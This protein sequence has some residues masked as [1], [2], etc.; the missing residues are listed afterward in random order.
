M[1]RLQFWYEFASPY[2]Y[3][4]A[5][6]IEEEA[7]EA[8]VEADWRPFLL[9][10][11]FAK[12]DWKTS[13]FNLFPE[14]G[15]YMRRDLERWAERLS[16]PFTMPDPFP[17][18]AVRAARI[19]LIAG[20]EGWNARFSKAVFLAEFSEGLDISRIDVLRGIVEDLGQDADAVMERIKDIAVKERLRAET[21]EAEDLGIFGAPTFVSPDGEL[22]WGNDRLGEALRWTAG[23][24]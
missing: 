17:Q 4:A 10:P 13:P 1:A 12:R 15:R 22:F 14:R 9:G 5:M 24:N 21:A 8:G 19:A 16:I 11:I 2:S 7:L 6:R 18:Y 3:L 20:D 23:H